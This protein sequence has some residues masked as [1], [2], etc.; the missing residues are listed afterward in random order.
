MSGLPTKDETQPVSEKNDPTTLTLRSPSVVEPCLSA[1]DG[2][3]RRSQKRRTRV[4]ASG[5][6]SKAKEARPLWCSLPAA[7]A[8]LGMA[9]E[10][11][12]RSLE[13]HAVRAP[14]GGTEASLDGVRGRKL[15]RCWRVSLSD[16]WLPPSSRRGR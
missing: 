12:R 9:P 5:A 14:D 11:L 2:P 15:G 1:L 13:R 6:S 4:A 3:A 7:A 10:A 8:L 16:R